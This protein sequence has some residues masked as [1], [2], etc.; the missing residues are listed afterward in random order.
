M[1]IWGKLTG[2]HLYPVGPCHNTK[3][4]RDEMRCPLKRGVRCNEVST[5]YCVQF[6]L[7]WAG[8]L[9]ISISGVPDG[10][11]LGA[12]TGLVKFKCILFKSPSL[13]QIFM[14]KSF[15]FLTSLE[16]FYVFIF[17]I[18]AFQLRKGQSNVQYS[19]DE[20]QWGRKGANWETGLSLKHWILGNKYMKRSHLNK[21][22][23]FT[24]EGYWK[25]KLSFKYWK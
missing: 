10:F 25:I 13:K 22:H 14:N 8:L 9:W 23:L 3:L 17:Y 1:T 24:F 16:M 19:A 15:S 7:G 20:E 21:T 6:W 18:F 12:S 2:A 5:K 11:Q 4:E